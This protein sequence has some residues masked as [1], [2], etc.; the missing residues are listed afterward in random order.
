MTYLIVALSFAGGF[1]AGS[2]L[3]WLMFE[4]QEWRVMRWNNETFGYRPI[5]HGAKI[6]RGEKV[7][8]TLEIDTTQLDEQGMIVE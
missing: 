1:L 8:M 7:I 3:R 6:S 4:A 5:G 2:F